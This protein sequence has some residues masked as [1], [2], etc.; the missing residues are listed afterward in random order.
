MNAQFTDTGANWR[1][2][3]G[4]AHCKTF[5]SRKDICLSLGIS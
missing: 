1:D 5:N 2:V 3:T 4:I